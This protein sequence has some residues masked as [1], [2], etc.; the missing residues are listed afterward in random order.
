M[1]GYLPLHEILHRECALRKLVTA[2]LVALAVVAG[3]G[4]KSAQ[5][6]D[7]VVTFTFTNDA[8]FTAFVK[9]FSQD[10]AWIW[11]SATTHYILDDNQ[12]KAARL[13]CN[14]GEKI[15]FGGSY[16]ENDTPRWRGVGYRGNKPCTACCLTCGAP[17]DNVEHHWR[18]IE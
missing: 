8:Q 5:A 3:T 11:P 12:P 17:G 13:A 14:I 7:G 15:C 9:M 16:R 2:I 10:R 6:Q 4:T 18:L 1:S